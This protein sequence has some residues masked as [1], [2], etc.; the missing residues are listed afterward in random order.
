MSIQL[1]LGSLSVLMVDV[2]V[3][4]VP[5]NVTV[6][7]T[8]PLLSIPSDA[9]DCL[10][11][12]LDVCEIIWGVEGV[13]EEDMIGHSQVGTSGTLVAQVEEQKPIQKSVNEGKLTAKI[14]SLSPWIMG[15]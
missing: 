2:F 14:Q 10:S 4:G 1:S 13:E 9:S 7:V 3:P 15:P 8:C 6:N 12:C 5:R 11:A